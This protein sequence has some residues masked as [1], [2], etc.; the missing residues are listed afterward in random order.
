MTLSAMAYVIGR[1]KPEIGVP[2]G[3]NVV[4]NPLA[5]IEMAVAVE[6]SFVRNTFTGAY[7]G[8]SGITD[9]DVAAYVRRL[10]GGPI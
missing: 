4:L 8:E 6:A 9:T 7:I 3:V 10:W 1:L 5:T 2:F